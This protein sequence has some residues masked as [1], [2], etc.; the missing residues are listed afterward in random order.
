MIVWAFSLI[1]KQNLNRKNMFFTVLRSEQF[2]EQNTIFHVRKLFW[3]GLKWIIANNQFPSFRVF[4]T[5]VHQEKKSSF[6]YA[7]PFATEQ[8][9]FRLRAA[10]GS[11]ISLWRT[12]LITVTFLKMSGIAAP[13]AD[14][15][16]NSRLQFSCSWSTIQS[17]SSRGLGKTSSLSK[18]F[19]IEIVKDI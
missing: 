13:T 17:T 5:N 8:N 12:L 3:N 1:S 4:P 6:D 7:I 10:P 19:H 15:T 11:L 16:T 14:C 18:I 2:W 9:L